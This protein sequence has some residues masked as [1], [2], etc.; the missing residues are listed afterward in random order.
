MKGGPR[1]NLENSFVQ[2]SNMCP[3]S[4][5]HKMNWR[6]IRIWIAANLYCRAFLSITEKQNFPLLH[7]LRERDTMQTVSKSIQ[8]EKS[9]RERN[10]KQE[11]VSTSSLRYAIG[12]SV[13]LDPLFAQAPDSS[14]GAMSATA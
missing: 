12:A 3:L 2:D 10:P 1:L 7:Q 4:I 5:Q 8:S 9:R 11:L 14:Y 13:C 6:E